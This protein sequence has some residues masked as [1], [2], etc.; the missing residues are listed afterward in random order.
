MINFALELAATLSGDVA[1]LYYVQAENPQAEKCVRYT[2]E[3]G[4]WVDLPV[5]PLALGRLSQAIINLLTARGPIPL[6]DLYGT[7]Q[8]KFWDLSRGLTSEEVLREAYLSPLWR[9]GLIAE[10]DGGY[11][12]GPR[13]GLIR[14]YEEALER[15]KELHLTLEQLARHNAW[16]EQ[17][18]LALA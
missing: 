10:A 7:L 12:I 3:N 8:T 4:Y 6:D 15:A 9:Q 18:T 1:R 13:W 16:I 2:A 17:E 14:P 11:I 5:M